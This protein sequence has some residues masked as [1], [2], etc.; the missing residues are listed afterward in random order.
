MSSRLPEGLRGPGSQ[1]SPCSGSSSSAEFPFQ[2]VYW[3]CL[4]NICNIRSNNIGKLLIN[5]SLPNKSCCTIVWDKSHR[6]TPRT[7]CQTC[8][9]KHVGLKG[10]GAQEPRGDE[11]ACSLGTAPAS[12]KSGTCGSLWR[13]SMYGLGIARPRQSKGPRSSMLPCCRN[14]L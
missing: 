5:C 3:P 7:P 10:A 4:N 11:I 12:S 2:P 8:S 1:Q 14:L 13:L 9:V 6:R